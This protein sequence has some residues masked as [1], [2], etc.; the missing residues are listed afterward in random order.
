VEICLLYLRESDESAEADDFKVQEDV[1]RKYAQ[2]KG[3]VIL[4]VYREAHSGKHSPFTRVVL[5][6]AMEE[7][8]SGKAKVL[9]CR[10]YDRLARTVEQTYAIL[11]EIE[12]L[13]HGRE[14]AAQEQLDRNSST[15]KLQFAVLAAASELERDRIAERIAGGKR[16]RAENGNLMAAPYPAYG[17]QWLDDVPGKRTA[18]VVDRESSAVVREIFERAAR[19]ESTRE[20]TRSLNNRGILPPSAYAALHRDLGKRKQAT[21]WHREPVRVII[22][23]AG[24]AGKPVAYRHKYTRDASDRMTHKLSDNPLSLPTSTWPALVS[25]E[26]F[27]LANARL[28]AN[29]PGR[30]PLDPTIALLKRHVYCGVCGRRCIAQRFGDRHSYSC[31]RRAMSATDP[32]EACPGG[33][34]AIRCHIVDEIGWE[35]VVV[36]LESKETFAKMLYDRVQSADDIESHVKASD[37]ALKAKQEEHE[38]LAKRIAMTSDDLV[39]QTIISQMELTAIEIRKLELQAQKAREQLDDRDAQTLYVQQT[40][41]HI[42][43]RRETGIALDIDDYDNLPWEIKR[44][45]VESSS[46]RVDL[47]PTGWREDGRRIVPYFPGELLGFMTTTAPR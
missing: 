38:N 19:G 28:K 11:F 15:A 16:K 32:S 20:I 23:H 1:C 40:L 47:Y 24:Y 31:V 10:T 5:R 46:V 8:K 13:Y 37:G 26:L 22:N 17:Y 30:K 35:A 39:A 9:V 21:L 7:I 3:Y 36:L 25:P 12:Q 42:Y 41:Q 29:T 6:Q 4:G 44:L 27:A 2:E 34:F 43:G 33:N 18:Y 45:A 14:E